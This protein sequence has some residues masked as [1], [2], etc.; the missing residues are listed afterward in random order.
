MDDKEFVTLGERALR[1]LRNNDEQFFF[2]NVGI[3]RYNGKRDYTNMLLVMYF[4]RNKNYKKCLHYLEDIKQ[5]TSDDLKQ[6]YS[7]LYWD[8]KICCLAELGK[9]QEIKKI[10]LDPEGVFNE[11]DDV[12]MERYSYAYVK[13]LSLK[14]GFEDDGLGI[15]RPEN[16]YENVADD[17]ECKSILFRCLGQDILNI[18]LDSQ[19][20]D[21]LKAA[22]IDKK[23]YR[24][25]KIKLLQEI[26][27]IERF[28]KQK[29]FTVSPKLLSSI[30]SYHN[31]I[32]NDQ[33]LHKEEL[34]AIFSH[35]TDE[36]IKTDIYNWSLAIDFFYAVDEPD[37]FV[38]K[39][40]CYKADIL[41]FLASHNY[42]V[43]K[44][45]LWLINDKRIATIDVEGL[46]FEEY[47]KMAISTA[48]PGIMEEIKIYSCD[49]NIYNKLSDNGKWAYESAIWQYENVM[50]D[51]DGFM[52][53]GL[54]SLS[55][56]R[57]MEIEF[58]IKI[59][60]PLILKLRESLF[61]DSISEDWPYKKIKNHDFKGF[62]LGEL[63]YFFK[64]VRKK[65]TNESQ[66]IY[67]IL[68]STLL[69]DTGIKML[70]GGEIEKIINQSIIE[71]YRN[72]PAHS[73]FLHKE[74]AFEA[75]QYV[76]D[77]IKIIFECCK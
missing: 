25:F 3:L 45:I 51:N 34:I 49:E 57:I 24:N 32:K 12:I 36:M 76:E 58:N 75:K 22:Q 61:I 42:Q 35:F 1:G 13:Y 19:R 4:F 20:L 23:I 68:Q 43:A 48:M 46:S 17:N 38:K 30:V 71:K 44:K 52:D 69:S 28:C 64:Y 15:F 47:W 31:N 70:L 16:L 41:F 10:F 73:R 39:F 14:N 65:E 40:Q 63:L 77:K 18:F 53:A 66:K 60:Q 67:D 9:F 29:Y 62:A 6:M 5:N 54:M 7:C 56:M 74:R 72:P 11:D 26:E 33:P 55:F 50:N 21:N 27:V 37:D 8:Y 2:E 59:I